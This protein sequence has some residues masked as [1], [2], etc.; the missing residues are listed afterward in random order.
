VDSGDKSN[1]AICKV[2]E[3]LEQKITEAYRVLGEVKFDSPN[4]EEEAQAKVNRLLKQKHAHT[5]KHGCL[6]D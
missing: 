4:S 3:E 6:R 2:R 1:M 5:L